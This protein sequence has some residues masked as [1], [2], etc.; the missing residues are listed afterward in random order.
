MG[1]SDILRLFG[2]SNNLDIL[3]TVSDAVILTG[4]GTG[5]DDNIKKGIFI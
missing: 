5:G 1:N 2:G 3:S 4:D